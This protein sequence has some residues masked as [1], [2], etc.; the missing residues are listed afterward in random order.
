MAGLHFGMET[1]TERVLCG[2]CQRERAGLWEWQA[3]DG[4]RGAIATVCPAMVRC[5]IQLG[6]M[7]LGISALFP[8]VFR[9]GLSL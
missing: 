7:E 3:G 6:W 5:T 1:G 4:F 2:I 9:Q 8:G